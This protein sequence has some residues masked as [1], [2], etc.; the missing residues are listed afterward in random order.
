MRLTTDSNATYT[1]V[2]Q[3]FLPVY[4]YDAND[5]WTYS[6]STGCMGSLCVCLVCLEGGWMDSQLWQPWR[7]GGTQGGGGKEK[8]M[9]EG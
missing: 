7:E 1:C 8:M 9:A 2:C 3:C 4:S 6:N 5:W